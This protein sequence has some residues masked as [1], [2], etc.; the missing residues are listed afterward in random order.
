MAESRDCTQYLYEGV[1][2]ERETNK[3]EIKRKV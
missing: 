3:R 2:E 1:G